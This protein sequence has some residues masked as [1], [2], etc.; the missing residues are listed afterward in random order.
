M[1]P[2]VGQGAIGIQLRAKDKVMHEIIAPLDHEETR[3]TVTAERTLLEALG[4]GCQ[5][6]LGGYAMIQGERLRLSAIVVAE[7]GRRS[8]SRVLEGSPSNP[9]ALGRETAE[10]LLSLGAGEIM[11]V[12]QPK[13]PKKKAR[14]R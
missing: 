11:G 9:E 5:V 14:A 1:C 8:F 12:E 7:D 4:G 6:P 10:K 2:A 13:K 3:T